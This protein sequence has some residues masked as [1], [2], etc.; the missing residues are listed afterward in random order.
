MMMMVMM[1]VTMSMTMTTMMSMRMM[2]MMTGQV[3]GADGQGG[4]LWDPG[5]GGAVRR[6]THGLVSSRDYSPAGAEDCDAL[7]L[8]WG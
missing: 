7:W 5:A 8:W 3:G 1:R 6:R 2:M 4:E